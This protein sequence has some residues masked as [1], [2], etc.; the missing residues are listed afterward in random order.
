MPT[1]RQ[2][3]VIAFSCVAMGVTIF[4]LPGCSSRTV[5]EAVE[6]PYAGPA[7][8]LDSKGPSHLVV[9]EAPS[10]G[11]GLV[12]DRVLERAGYHDIFVT[13]RTP[14][15]RFVH[16]QAVTRLRAM[17]PLASTVPVRVCARVLGAGEPAEGDEYPIAIDARR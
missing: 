6:T 14:D 4:A 11:Y 16:T 10:G 5:P 1:I 7:I 2:V 3:L 17:A 15:P 9:L 8:T 12:V 13:V